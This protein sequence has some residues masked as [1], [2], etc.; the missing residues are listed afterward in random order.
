MN[1]KFFKGLTLA[2]PV[3][4]G[5]ITACSAF[6]ATSCGCSSSEEKINPLPEEVYNIND[7]NTLLGF[8][9][10][11]LANTDAYDQYNTI[12]I[13]VRVKDVY[14][15]AFCIFDEQQFTP[16][17]TKIPPYI[18]KLIFP[19]KSICWSIAGFAFYG[20]PSL[21]SITL[22][23]SLANLNDGAY[24]FKDCSNLTSIV[25][26]SFNVVG[27][28][29]FTQFQNVPEIGTVEVT[30]PI[31]EAHN[32]AHLLEFLQDKCGLPAGWTATN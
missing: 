32:S 22:P 30:N 16:I 4:L 17:G 5:C 27:P 14:F 11:F 24:I 23:N 28:S 19:K 8:T 9:D 18:T 1:K 12:E 25:W 10:E 3:L 20:C 6:A 31:D 13:P 21:T 15:A 26:D 7:S 29:A 2:I